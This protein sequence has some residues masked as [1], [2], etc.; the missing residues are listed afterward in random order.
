M[1]LTNLFVRVKLLIVVKAY[2]V[3]HWMA[4]AFMG[5]C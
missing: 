1:D 5:V 3:L 2:F 4:K